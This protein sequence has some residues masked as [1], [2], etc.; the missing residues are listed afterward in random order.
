MKITSE[1][2]Q[3][4]IRIAEP[5]VFEIVKTSLSKGKTGVSVV[6]MFGHLKGRGI[7]RTKPE[8]KMAATIG[9]SEIKYDEFAMRKANLSWRTGSDC[10]EI[11]KNFYHSLI[12]EEGT[13][14]PYAGSN[15]LNVG[16]LRLVVAT[17]ALKEREDQ[18]ISILLLTIIMMLVNRKVIVAEL[19]GAN[20]VI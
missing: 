12:L 13:D 4:A 2:V 15:V 1:I 19:P 16:D 14:T 10:D 5:T 18:A 3:E 17:S 8:L 6:V 7:N 11:T 9:S 20:G